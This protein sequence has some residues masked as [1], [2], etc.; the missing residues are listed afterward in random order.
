MKNSADISVE[1]NFVIEA[2]FIGLKE[3]T[4]DKIYSSF[5]ING[6]YQ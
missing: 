4:L 6:L 1:D 3:N 2:I 5:M